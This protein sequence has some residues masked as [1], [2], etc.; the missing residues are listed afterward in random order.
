VIGRVDIVLSLRIVE[1]RCASFDDDVAVVLFAVVDARFAD[2]GASVRNRGY[3]AQIKEW[4]PFA[5]LASDRAHHRAGAVSKQ[6]VAV[7]PC[8]GIRWTQGGPQS[9]ARD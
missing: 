3:V 4:Q 1:L 7:D 2:L 9:A 5:A 8:L 6:H